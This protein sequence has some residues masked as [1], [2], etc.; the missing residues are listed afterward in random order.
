MTYNYKILGKT[1]RGITALELL[2]VFAVLAIIFTVVLK[3]FSAFRNVQAINSAS[4]QVVSL[5]NEARSSTVASKE[6]SQYGVH[7]ESGRVVYFKGASFSEPSSYNKEIKIDSSVKISG[8][9]LAGGGSDVVF[10]QLTGDTLNYG[11]ISIEAN[12]NSALKRIIT[13]T[14]TGISSRN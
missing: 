12:S 11:T 9:S 10:Q 3:P 8:I 4:I 6:S 13:I 2:V 14:S 7:I 5:L 1:E